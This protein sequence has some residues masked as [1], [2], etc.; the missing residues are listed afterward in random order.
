M[1]ASRVRHLEY[2]IR[3]IAARAQKIEKSGKKVIKLNIG[4]PLKFDFE[5]P[6]A[7]QKGLAMNTDKGFYAPSEGVHELREAIAE[8]ETRKGIDVSVEKIYITQGL[9]EAIMFLL[10]SLIEPG[11]RILLPRPVY[12]LYFNFTGFF[13]GVPLFYDAL[14]GDLEEIKEKAKNAKAMVVINPNNPTGMVYEKDFVKGVVDISE[15]LR[16]P[17][18]FDEIYDLLYFD[19]KPFNAAKLGGDF[20]VVLNGFS[21]IF[22]APGYRVGYLYFAGDLPE[23]ET[24]IMKFLRTRLS[25]NAP[26]QY[27]AAEAMREG[28]SWIPTLVEKLRKRRDVAYRELSKIFNVKKPEGAFYIFPELP[29][30]MDD[31]DFALRLLDEKQVAVVP[32]SGFAKPGHFRMVFLPPEDVIKE[33]VEKIAE[34]TSQ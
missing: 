19:K 6:E 30:G 15:D 13:G 4:D 16:I 22:L 21:K 34:I 33:A 17:V 20:T 27:A 31:W 8:W 23:L 1:L 7:F 11:D 26:V 14:R 9:S 10:G 28:G 3:E 29:A 5:V 12:P 32:G 25:A 18:I 2:A 24:A